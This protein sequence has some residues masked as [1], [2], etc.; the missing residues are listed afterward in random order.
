M[1]PAVPTYAYIMLVL[2]AT[3]LAV[4]VAFAGYLVDALSG[5]LSHED[6]ERVEIFGKLMSGVA[7]ALAAWGKMAAGNDACL[8]DPLAIHPR[9][10]GYIVRGLV[11]IV[12]VYGGLTA[13]NSAIVEF[14][15][16]DFR[17]RAYQATFARSVLAKAGEESPSLIAVAPG[18]FMGDTS[19]A[20]AIGYSVEE[21]GLI[22]TEAA[23]GSPDRFRR[24]FFEAADLDGSYAKYWDG[25]TEYQIEKMKIPVRQK[26][27]WAEMKARQWQNNV[28]DTPGMKN[29]YFARSVVNKV[30]RKFFRNGEWVTTDYQAFER[31][32][33]LRANEEIERE[34]RSRVM[35]STGGYLKPGL[36]KEEFIE[37]PVIQKKIR[38]HL[39]I[40]DA[41]VMITPWMPDEAFRK[42]IYDPVV[43][44]EGGVTAHKLIANPSHFGDRG[45]LAHE[46]RQ[47]VSAVVAPTL[48]V[49]LSLLGSL[50]HL[51][52]VSAY[53]HMI[54]GGLITRNRLPS[55]I[56]NAV[57]AATALGIVGGLGI[58]HASSASE[59]VRVEYSTSGKGIVKTALHGLLSAS[60]EAM[61]ALYPVAVLAR[62]HGPF[63]L[64]ADTLPPP[65]SFVR[66]ATAQIKGEEQVKGEVGAVPMPRSKPSLEQPDEGQGANVRMPKPRP[67]RTV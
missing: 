58:Q 19:V 17:Q 8:N 60:A 37:S 2:T 1:R 45:M 20:D 14:S 65:V 7:V 28:P 29:A 42:H 27:E 32:I 5:T 62:E 9:R 57:A 67:G 61:D 44:G 43:K 38:G 3:Y 10:R 11:L 40:T 31:A 63:L 26:K 52:K 54:L 22:G 36:S 6:I 33:A 59:G 51:V 21:I 66:V 55:R 64:V 24:D 49:V 46:G 18:L 34:Y 4:E 53:L 15:S 23:L 16:N 50:F 25:V 13:F 30:G 47:A 39:N 41:S 35:S 12:L 48:A 56:R